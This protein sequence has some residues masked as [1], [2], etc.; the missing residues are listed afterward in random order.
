LTPRDEADIRRAIKEQAMKDNVKG[1]GQVWSERGPVVYRI[2]TIEELADNVAA[3][4]ADGARTGTFPELARYTFIL[5]KKNG[6]WDVV[7]RIPVCAAPGF[8]LLEEPGKPK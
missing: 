5:A 2:R 8:Q 4:D 7:R 3:A 1:S 6:G